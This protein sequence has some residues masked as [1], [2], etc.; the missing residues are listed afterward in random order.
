MWRLALGQATGSSHLRTGTGCQ[1]RVAC[2]LLRAAGGESL[3]VAVADGAGSAERGAEGAEAAVRGVLGHVKRAKAADAADPEP[4]LVGAGLAAR[5]AVLDLAA[6]EGE[7]PRSFA[8]TL[9]AALIT[10]TGGAALQIGDGVLVAGDARGDWAWLFWP[11]RGEFTNATYFLTDRDAL[12]RM[13]VRKL[14]EAP[15]DLAVM[16]DG[17][18]PLALHYASRSVHAPFFRGMFSPLHAAGASESTGPTGSTGPRS[19]GSKGGGV[20]E[21]L[22]AALGT[23]LG[24][25]RVRARTDDD[26]SLVLATQHAS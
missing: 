14:A 19:N 17:L 4:V 26:C 20:L 24:S 15:V 25:D 2:A 1:D 8:T 11:Q 9:L 22:S 23:F 12:E 13:R 21:G 6:A 5:Q 18:E 7:P 16:T 10:P 3:V